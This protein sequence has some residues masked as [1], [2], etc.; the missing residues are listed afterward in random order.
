[1]ALMSELEPQGRPAV[2]RTKTGA[3]KRVV[4][5]KLTSVRFRRDLMIIMTF[6]LVELDLNKQKKCR[7][8]KKDYVIFF[9]RSQV[10]N[11]SWS[12]RLFF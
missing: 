8:L 12:I 6:L 11:F 2:E 1:M 10:L 5:R 7:F 9:E 3:E 4:V